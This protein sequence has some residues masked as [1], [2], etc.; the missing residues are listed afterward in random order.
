MKNY[1]LKIVNKTSRLALMILLFSS[2]LPLRGYSQV[3][4]VETLIKMLKSSYVRSR[5]AEKLGEIKDPRAV[6]PLIAG[7][8][9]ELPD[10]RMKAA[11]ALGEIKDTRAIEPLITTLKDEDSNVQRQASRV[12][13]KM[14]K[15]AIKPFF[16]VLKN[17]YFDVWIL[18]PFVSE[19]KSENLEIV[20]KKIS[21]DYSFFIRRGEPGTEDILIE[22]L[23]K[24]GTVGMAE[25]FLNCG[26]N[27]LYEAARA[28]LEKSGF[29]IRPLSGEESFPE[30]QAK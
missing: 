20:L 14:G 8:K 22:A 21:S 15:P 3:N 13:G 27:E 17:L 25:A 28:L 4:D 10:V 1:K 11:W 16:S 23:N 7:L 29:I 9:D 5:V 18:G 2:Y 30:W 24:Y 26:N 19:L 12:L 6:E